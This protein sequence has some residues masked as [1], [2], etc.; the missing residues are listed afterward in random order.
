VTTYSVSV[1]HKVHDSN[2]IVTKLMFGG[3][4]PCFCIVHHVKMSTTQMSLTI[5]IPTPQAERLIVGA[6][7]AI[8][9]VCLTVAALDHEAAAS[10]SFVQFDVVRETLSRSTLGMLGAG[11]FVNVERSLLVGDERGGHDLSGHIDGTVQIVGHDTVGET[12]DMQLNAPDRL[13]NYIFEKG[14]IA[15]NGVSL[16]IGTVDLDLGTFS[17]HLIPETLRRTTFHRKSLGM[18]VNVEIDRTTQVTVDSVTQ[19]L[20]EEVAPLVR[21]S[22][23]F[24]DL[25]ALLVN[26]L[27]TTPRTNLG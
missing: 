1:I 4:V 23:Q 7:V 21:S 6:S 20:R 26:H 19:W 13:M 18:M 5:E 22:E 15:L 10:Y 17:V 12:V 25:K 27:T 16:T 11:D 2:F 14:Y 3:I 9:G 24:E 8:D